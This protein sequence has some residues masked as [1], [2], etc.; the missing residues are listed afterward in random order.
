MQNDAHKSCM[1]P[2]SFF[3][4]GIRPEVHPVLKVECELFPNQLRIQQILRLKGF[5]DLFVF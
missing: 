4:G 2:G 5:H 1:G 3:V